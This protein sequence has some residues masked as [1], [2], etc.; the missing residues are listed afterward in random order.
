MIMYIY[1]NYF[2]IINIQMLIYRVLG[3]IVNHVFFNYIVININKKFCNN[4]K[5]IK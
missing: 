2:T 5:W 4:I 1:Y 3:I